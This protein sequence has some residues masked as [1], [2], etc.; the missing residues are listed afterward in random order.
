MHRNWRRF[1]EIFGSDSDPR[2]FNFDGEFCVGNRGIVEFIE[3]LKLAQEFLYDLLGASQEQQIKPKKF[4][5]ISVDIALIGHTNNPEY[6]KLRGN[7]SMEALRDRTVKIDVPYLLE[8][9]KEQAILEAYYGKGRVRQHIAPHTLEI[10]ALWSILTRLE[11]DK[12]HKLTLVQKT[13]L[14]DGRALP[15]YTEDSVKEL[16]AKYPG[17]GMYA[18][19]SCRYTQDK[20]SNC[21]SDRHDYINPFMVLNELREGLNHSSLIVN[22]D[23]ISKYIACIEL[24][25]KELDE[26]L[27]K[28][29][30]QALIGDEKAI[31]RLCANYIDNVIAYINKTKIRHPLTGQDMQPDE[32]LMRSIEEKIDI[33]EVGADEFRRGLAVFIGSLST[34][35]KTFRWDSNPRLKEALEAKLF[36]DTKDHINL[37]KLSVKDA[38]T[39][40]PDLQEKIDLVKKRL[41]DMFGYNQQSATDVLDYISSIFARGDVADSR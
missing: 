32:R 27:K 6:E 10:A 2:A 1:H 5:Q 34:E 22:K 8:W 16:R 28:E 37:S 26:I 33:P 21:L 39:V 30:Q 7:Q 29:V 12:D 19:I 36:E 25:K 9:S 14:Y 24:A 40:D 35:G 13:K 38:S 23:E 20:I 17:E 41:I 3:M 15:G 4:P 31:V 11:D 18:G